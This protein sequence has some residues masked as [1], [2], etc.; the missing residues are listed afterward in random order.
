MSLSSGHIVVVTISD[1]VS[2][3]SDWEN[4]QRLEEY[5]ALLILV[6]RYS[7]NVPASIKSCCLQIVCEFSHERARYKDLNMV[8]YITNC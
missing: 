7:L 6:T 4:Y 1:N 8:V 3:Y 5:C 2:H